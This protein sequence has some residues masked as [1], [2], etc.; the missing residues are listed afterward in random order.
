M[1]LPGS[2]N[3]RLLATVFAGIAF[4]ATFFAGLFGGVGFGMILMRALLFAL[5]LGMVGFGAGFLL[6]RFAAEAW[7]GQ[8][9]TARTDEELTESGD[10]TD[11]SSEA[12]G[13]MVDYTVGQDVQE[14]YEPGPKA[15]L[16]HLPDSD[17]HV[18]IPSPPKGSRRGGEVVGNYR[19][20]DDKKFPDDPED[21]AKAVRT[22][23]RK[24]D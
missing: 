23:M 6:E 7:S 4:I 2:E 3:T 18:S 17:E 11:A 1:E 10:T 12:P 14:E 24:D 13:S 15:D 9:D 20:I 22:M 5:L 8:G 16:E 21:Y 19:I